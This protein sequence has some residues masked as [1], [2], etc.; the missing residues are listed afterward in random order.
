MWPVLRPAA[1]KCPPP[2]P[3][4]LPLAAAAGKNAVA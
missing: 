2:L 3:L 1:S 4:P